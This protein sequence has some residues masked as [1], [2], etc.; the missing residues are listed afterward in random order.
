MYCFGAGLQ[1]TAAIRGE[2]VECFARGWLVWGLNTIIIGTNSRSHSDSGPSYSVQGGRLS[3]KYCKTVEKRLIKRV[4]ISGKSWQQKS[5][6][7]CHLISVKPGT[8]HAH[9]FLA[10]VD[11]NFSCTPRWRWDLRPLHCPRRIDTIR[12]RDSKTMSSQQLCQAAQNHDVRMSRLRL[13]LCSGHY[14][15]FELELEEIN[16]SP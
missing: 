2:L 7:R 3:A 14:E 6:R 8:E 16:K 10:A 15:G 1:L 4:G 11:P 5:K 9:E 13:S 12:N